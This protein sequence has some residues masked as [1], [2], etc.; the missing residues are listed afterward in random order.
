M[1]RAFAGARRGLPDEVTMHSSLNRP[2]LMMPTS[3]LDEGRNHATC[4]LA[5]GQDRDISALPRFH[6]SSG[7]PSVCLATALIRRAANMLKSILVIVLGGS[8][9]LW[10][11]TFSGH[12]NR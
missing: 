4:L 12:L 5:Q 3:T 8:A 2:V 9:G 10:R 11:S 7:I 1:Q 6:A